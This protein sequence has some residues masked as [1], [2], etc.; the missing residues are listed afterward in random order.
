MRNQL[1]GRTPLAFVSLVLLAA[2]PALAHTYVGLE[3][4][5]LVRARVQSLNGAITELPVP[6]P[7]T[8]LS[9]V[10][11]RVRNTGP[12]DSRI[13]AVGLELPGDLR[14]FTLISPTGA[15]FHLAEQVSHVPGLHDVTLDFALL[16][17]RTV[18]GGN[19]RVG[20]APAEALT[21][22]CVSGPFPRDIPIERLLDSGVLRVQRVGA[23]GEAGDI[24]VWENR[25]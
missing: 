9:I 7:G 15:G 3:F 21:T 18:G 11:F 16:T 13:T 10:C 1:I 14:G 12:F 5:D 6:V 25:P 17:G 22:F 23:D 2:A 4:R 19:P 24:A 20:L 8:E